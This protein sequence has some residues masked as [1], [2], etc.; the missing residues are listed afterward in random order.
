MAGLEAHFS[1]GHVSASYG[2]NGFSV[3]Q[4]HSWA[5]HVRRRRA[6]EVELPLDYFRIRS[7]GCVDLGEH[8]S[9]NPD[10]CGRGVGGYLPEYCPGVKTFPP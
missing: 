6:V 2:V 4:E 7:L 1:R 3:R 9:L 10:R 5:R 8:P